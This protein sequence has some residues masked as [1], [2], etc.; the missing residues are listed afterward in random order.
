MHELTL[1]TYMTEGRQSSGVG[2]QRTPAN[3]KWRWMIGCLLDLWL[4]FGCLKKSEI[5]IYNPD[6]FKFEFIQFLTFCW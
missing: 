5:Y 4:T 6:H 1:T 3:S 2:H